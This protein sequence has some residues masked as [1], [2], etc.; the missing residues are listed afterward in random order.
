[1]QFAAFRALEDGIDV[2]IQ[3]CD[4][5]APWLKCAIEN[6]S[7]RIRRFLP[8]DL[9]VDVPSNEPD[10]THSQRRKCLGYRTPTEAFM[11]N[12]Q[13]DAGSPTLRNTHDA[14]GVA[15]PVGGFEDVCPRRLSHSA[16]KAEALRSHLSGLQ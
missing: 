2:R 11:A 10:R 8:S 4:P 9:K 14:L 16:A 7:E 1:M 3:F 15:S 6:A 5:C 13:E 12:L